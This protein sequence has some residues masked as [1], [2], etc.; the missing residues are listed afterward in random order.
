VKTLKEQVEQLKKQISQQ[1]VKLELSEQ[2]AREAQR[3]ARESHTRQLEAAEREKDRDV[4][5]A[6]SGV[7][8]NPAQHFQVLPNVLGG[9]SLLTSSTGPRKPKIRR[10]STTKENRER[11]PQ[12]EKG[13][14]ERASQNKTKVCRLRL[15]SPGS[16]LHA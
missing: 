12:N 6:R 10:T 5:M 13:K 15:G 7:A 9:E 16:K 11:Q 14:L 8:L 4:V 2:E 1:E 3:Q